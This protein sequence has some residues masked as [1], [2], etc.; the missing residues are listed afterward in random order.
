MKRRNPYV[1]RCGGMKKINEMRCLD[2]AVRSDPF[3]EFM[4]S[5]PEEYVAR[6][7]QTERKRG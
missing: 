2:C 4:S 3:M 5:S 1:C 6:L 7:K